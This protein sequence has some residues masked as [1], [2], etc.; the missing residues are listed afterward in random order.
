VEEL[1]ICLAPCPG[2][3]QEEKFP[4]N[5]DV[6]QEQSVSLLYKAAMGSADIIKGD[7][8]LSLSIGIR[9]LWSHFRPMDLLNYEVKR[10][11][12]RRC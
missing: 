6:A 2:E 1:I 5:L 8:V 12:I 9:G 4:G 7:E 11:P 3:K 10:S